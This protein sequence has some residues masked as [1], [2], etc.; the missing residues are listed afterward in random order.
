MQLAERLHVAPLL[1]IRVWEPWGVLLP[2]VGL[3]WLLLGFFVLTV[4]HNGWLFYQGGDE[5]FFYTSAWSIAHGHVPDAAIGWGWSY[6]LAPVAAIFGSNFLAA[7]PA[8]I[9]IQTLILLPLGLLAAY[10][11]AARLGGRLFGYLVAFLWVV[12]PYAL[13]PLWDH[14]YHQKYVEQFLPQ[15]FG[16]TGLGDFPSMVLVVCAAYLVVRVL[17]ERSLPL[18]AL[19][20]LTTAFVIGIKPANALFLSGVVLAFLAARRWREALVFGAAM[21]PGLIVL[22]LWK[23]KGL[24]SL[25]VFRSH[26][27]AAAAMAPP[28]VASL[29]LPKS[30][31][32]DWHHFGQNLNYLREFFWSVRVVEWFVVAGFVGLLRRTPAKALLIGGWFG[33]FLLV[34]GTSPQASIEAGTFLRLF[35]PALPAL[36]ILGA[37]VLL[38]VPTFATSVVERFP[39]FDRPLNWRSK[40]LGAVA[41]VLAVLPLVLFAAL[42]PVHDARAA[43]FFTQNVYVPV[44]ADLG[45]RAAKGPDGVRLSWRAPSARARVFYRVVRSPADWRTVQFFPHRINGVRCLPPNGGAKD[46]QVEMKTITITR[47]RAYV[48]RGPLPNARY[49]YRIGVSANWADDTSGGDVL[50]FSEPVVVPGS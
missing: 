16:L 42:T 45:L 38:L 13:I 22:A 31:N 7:L 37:G 2:L 15:A 4:R 27:T 23:Q 25:P 19:A 36:L 47:G 40:P 8:I 30:V 3:Q 5:T 29:H 32:L 6:V 50:Y 33:A 28:L 26:G 49:A 43:K 44:N 9:L 48:D 20:G 35:M 34:K 39:T 12:G 1:R 41:L 18:A 14:R 46:C 24:G 10:G 21:V 11:L 17:D